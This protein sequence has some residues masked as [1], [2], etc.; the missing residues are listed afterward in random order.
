MGVSIPNAEELSSYQETIKSIK[1]GDVRCIWYIP[2]KYD[3][4]GRLQHEGRR[5]SAEIHFAE[6]KT[7]FKWIKVMDYDNL[8]DFEHLFRL[9]CC[10]QY[11]Q[12]LAESNEPAR[13]I[14]KKWYGEVSVGMFKSSAQQISFPS[15]D[16]S[17]TQNT[18]CDL[19]ANTRFT[20]AV[21]DRRSTLRSTKRSSS[22]NSCSDHKVL[23]TDTASDLPEF[24]P[25]T[26][27][28]DDTVLQRILQ[29][30]G[31]ST[32]LKPIPTGSIY[33]F[34]IASFPGLVKIG[35]TTVSVA[36]RLNYWTK[37]GYGRAELIVQFDNVPMAKSVE[38]FIHC[39]LNE[40]WR[41]QLN[42]QEH[43]TSH[44]EWF[45]TDREEAVEVCK[46][47]T[48]WMK[49]AKPYDGETF[50]L[51]E[52]WRNL[53]SELRFWDVEVT[54]HLLMDLYEM[55]KDEKRLDDFLLGFDVK[56][57]KE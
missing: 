1:E 19:A 41:R 14:S 2:A 48:R 55:V 23:R 12:H 22:G 15:N 10:K 18:F 4:K 6:H 28:P 43:G 7:A 20:T 51:R 36:S 45:E 13:S 8:D 31:R 57:E 25:H 56:T 5:C 49:E 37:C 11:H 17:S 42:C 33:V 46:D 32:M 47:W 40:C 24:R 39:E 3:G 16:L 34:H 44:M 38:G 26:I 50:V 54:G 52:Q 35:F 27:H 53:M 29:P 21:E 30:P 9:K